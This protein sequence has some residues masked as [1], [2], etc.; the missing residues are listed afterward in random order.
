MCIVYE[1]DVVL[2]CRTIFYGLP[3]Q[4]CSTHSC[5]SI[6]M[7]A[8]HTHPNALHSCPHRRAYCATIII[9]IVVHVRVVHLS[10]H[11]LRLHVD[12]GTISFGLLRAVVL[13]KFRVVSVAAVEPFFFICAAAAAAAC[14]VVLLDSLHAHRVTGY[15][16]S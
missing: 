13:I 16:Y 12:C 5:Q 4:F 9:M 15:V 10:W 11:M 7:M 8:Q 6:I 3:L 1:L 14:C 2:A